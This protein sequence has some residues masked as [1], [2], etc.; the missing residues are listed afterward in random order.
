MDAQTASA[1]VADIGDGIEGC[2]VVL[3]G[4]KGTVRCGGGIMGWAG[5]LVE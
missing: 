2:G 5:W 3:V 1:V 4:D